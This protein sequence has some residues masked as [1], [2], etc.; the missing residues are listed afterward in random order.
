M[1]SA[2]D[3]FVKER[4]LSAVSHTKEISLIQVVSKTCLV[5]AGLDKLLKIWH[6]PEGCLPE[7]GSKIT[8]VAKFKVEKELI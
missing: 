4:V 5:T 3:G 7:N 6:M 8:L 2:L 1:V